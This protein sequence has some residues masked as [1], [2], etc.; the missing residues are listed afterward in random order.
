MVVRISAQNLTVEKQQRATSL[1]LRCG[2][3]RTVDGQ[4][5][6]ECGDVGGAQLARVAQLVEAH[7]ACDP[8][9]IA[10]LG[11]PRVVFAAEQRANLVK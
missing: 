9:D 10:L 4:V 8:I 5:G 2:G 1:V 3:D 11:A 6:Q 7:V